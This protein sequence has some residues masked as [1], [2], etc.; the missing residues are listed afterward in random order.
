MGGA[1][2][3]QLALDHPAR[4]AGLIL[5]AT[6]A[7]LRVAPAIMEGVLVD[8]DTALDTITAYAW[9]PQAPEELVRLGRAQLAQVSAQVAHGDYTAC[10]AFD[11]MG[12]LGQITAPTLIVSGT[13]DR[14]T[15]AKYAAKLA[16][17]IPNAQLGLIENAGHMVMLEQPEQVGQAVIK[18]LRM[19]GNS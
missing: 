14:L 12:R 16:E 5:V 17:D 1:I 2:A 19:C 18:F 15:P 9:G 7:R 4:V 11:V 3:Q 10:N 8:Y 6:G 13:A